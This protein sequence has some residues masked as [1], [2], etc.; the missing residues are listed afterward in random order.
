MERPLCFLGKGFSQFIVCIAAAL[1]GYEYH[2]NWVGGWL[3]G[4]GASHWCCRAR[5]TAL[6]SGG[7]QVGSAREAS[8]MD[9][10]SGALG[11]GSKAPLPADGN[12]RVLA[13]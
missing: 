7:I 4:S 12:H 10:H 3:G 11:E 2:P 9:G 1:S 6:R 5:Q 8:E 13:L